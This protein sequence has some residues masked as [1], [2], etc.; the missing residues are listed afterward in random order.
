M[1]ELLFE[2]CW[3]YAAREQ[4]GL[5][6]QDGYIC[7]VQKACVLVNH[8]QANT[9]DTVFLLI[10]VG[11]KLLDLVEEK[12]AAFFTKKGGI[13]VGKQLLE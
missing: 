13:M 6:T 11:I 4:R 5:R 3:G 9:N 7:T 1:K 2:C 10:L 12:F 8:L